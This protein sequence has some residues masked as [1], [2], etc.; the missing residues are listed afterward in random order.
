MR[1]ETLDHFENKTALTIFRR[2]P[3]SLPRFVYRFFLALIPLSDPV[4]S[5]A[6]ILMDS[7]FMTKTKRFNLGFMLLFTHVETNPVGNHLGFQSYMET[8]NPPKKLRLCTFESKE[9]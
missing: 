7:G 4:Y 2:P 9:I 1:S 8:L 6:K 5:K 3:F